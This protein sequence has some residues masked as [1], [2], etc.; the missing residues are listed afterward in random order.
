MDWAMTPSDNAPLVETPPVTAKLSI[1]PPLPPDP[2]VPPR[3]TP[4]VVDS[5][6]VSVPEIAVPP[7]PPPP[8]IDWPRTPAEWSPVVVTAPVISAVTM[9]AVPP[10][11]PR[12]PIAAL[13]S[14]DSP[15][16]TSAVMAFPPLPPPPPIDWTTM[17]SARSPEVVTAAD[18]VTDAIVVPSSS[19]L[20]PVSPEPPTDA[21]SCVL[22]PREMLPVTAMPPL[23]PPPPMDWARMPGESAPTV[24]MMPVLVTVTGSA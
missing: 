14:V 20:P 17:P 7:L 2:P 11:L 21:P 4:R 3:V 16:A 6:M 19:L 10:P 15:V 8:P 23:P 9:P 5:L 24:D 13:R 18:D 22:S 1:S 12:P